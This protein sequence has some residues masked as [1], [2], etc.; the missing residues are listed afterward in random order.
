MIF[1]HDM[2]RCLRKLDAWALESIAAYALL[3]LPREQ[4]AAALNLSVAQADRRYATALD[5]LSAVLLE[6]G[7]MSRNFDDPE[8]N[9]CTHNG[10]T[11]RTVDTADPAHS[12]PRKPVVSTHTSRTGLR[13]LR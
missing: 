13:I 7:L 2:E 9:E 8:S 6:S 12:L 5:R 11:C 3:E 4:A 1:V 10:R